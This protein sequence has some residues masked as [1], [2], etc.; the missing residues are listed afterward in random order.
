MDKIGI[1]VL[2]YAHGHAN[3]YSQELVK[4]DDVKMVACWDDNEAR[5]KEAAAKYGMA[6][7]PR[8]DDVIGNPD[9]DGVI[10]TN[11]T[12]R[13][14]ELVTAAA[15]AGK[16]ILCQK[17][18]A[19]TLEDCDRMK[20]AVE[21]AGVKFSMAFQMRCDPVNI[22]IK[23]LLDSGVI[24]KV[25]VLRRRHCIGVLF[26]ENFVKGPTRWHIDP[27]KNMGMFMD[28]AVHATDFLRWVLG[29]PVSVMAEIDNI[30]TNVAPDDNGVA[31]YRFKNKEIVTLF[32]G[33]TTL[34]G[35]NTTEIYGDKGV[36]IQNYGDGP[37]CAMP[38][39]ADAVPLKMFLKDS[40]VPGWQNFNL[41]IPKS[42]GERIAAVPRPFIEYLKGNRGPIATALDG[43]KSVEMV[44]GA[45]RSAREGRRIFF[46]LK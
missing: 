3:T 38:R 44:L 25:A 18:M 26:S 15:K 24:G 17:P 42:Q 27:E 31:L 36:I 34:A 22:K 2:S 29:D 33:S 16:H 7:S 23:E 46:P 39:P 10:V 21:K 37:S 40:G 11:E 43:K 30:H 19:L 45:Y 14:A 35:E 6:Y 12:Y 32:N 28:D 20:E 4:Y 1:A 41:P 8:L 13:H 5:G 9:V